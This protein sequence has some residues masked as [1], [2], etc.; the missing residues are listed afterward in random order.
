MLNNL[1]ER[2][3]CVGDLDNVWTYGRAQARLAELDKEEELEKELE[4]LENQAFGKWVLEVVGGGVVGFGVIKLIE[5]LSDII[6]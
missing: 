1:E 3:Q 6:S 4:K 5:L 2:K